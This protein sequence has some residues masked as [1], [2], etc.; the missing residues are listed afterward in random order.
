MSDF[1]KELKD[2]TQVKTDA[3]LDAR[4]LHLAR[5]RASHQQKSSKRWWVGLSAS[6]VAATLVVVLINHQK[7]SIPGIWQ[8]NPEMLTH[9][10]EVEFYLETEQLQDEDWVELEVAT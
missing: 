10:Q 6:L 4:I 8:E 9:M 1:F 7:D 2:K 5:T 3:Q